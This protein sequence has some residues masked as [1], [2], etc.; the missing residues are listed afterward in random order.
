MAL[1]TR[2]Y[3]L[4]GP[5]AGNLVRY[6]SPTAVPAATYPTPTIDITI[7][8]A[9][10]DAVTTLDEYMELQGY[11]FGPTVPVLNHAVIFDDAVPLD[12]V[13]IRSDRAS[14]QSPIDNTQAGITNLGSENGLGTGATANYA[15]V[16]GGLNNEASGV[17]STVAGGLNNEASGDTSTVSGGEFNVASGYGAYAE[18]ESNTA[19][20][21]YSHAEGFI[22]TALGE[23]AHA[24]GEF[25]DANGDW[26]HAEGA[27]NLASG[28]GAHVEGSSNVASGDDSHAEGVNTTASADASHAEGVNTTASG[29]HSHAEGDGTT[30]AAQDSHAEGDGSMCDTGADMSH[31]EG[32]S[33]YCGVGAIAAH[34]EGSNTDA[35]ARRSHAEGEFTQAGV[36]ALVGIAAH[37]E[38][39][40]TDALGAASH[41]EGRD[42]VANGDYSHACGMSSF[43]RRETQWSYASGG[44]TGDGVSTHLLVLRGTTPGLAISELVELLFGSGGALTLQL[45]DGHAY[46]FKVSAVIGANQAG[47]VRVSRTIEI[48]FNARRDAGLTVITA[49]GP[50]AA[51]GDASTATWTLTPTVGAAPDRIVLTFA[52]GVGLASAAT[53]IAKVEF[54][55]VLWA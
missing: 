30:A 5:T 29:L 42:T 52:T 35:L 26:S 43:A 40:F 45:T 18:A 33:G 22:N 4:V 31:A 55:E 12:R 47:P 10:A 9:V 34:A 44:A 21:D 1:V 28:T 41:A 37:A 6:V 48:K 8:N 23:S 14:N 3:N 36:S 19:S 39:T 2:R 51:F 20:G 54:T 13:N 7:D 16:G 50:G 49:I 24:E 46:A 32:Q 25:N 53:I 15:T 27:G 11:A 17:N 38:G